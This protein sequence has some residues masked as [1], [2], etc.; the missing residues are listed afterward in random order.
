MVWLKDWLDSNGFNWSLFLDL[1]S[2]RVVRLAACD[3]TAWQGVDS[4]TELSQI[5][6]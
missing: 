4:E 2:K 1:E 5:L 6:Y 3:T